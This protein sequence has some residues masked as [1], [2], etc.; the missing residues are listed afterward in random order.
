MEYM[1]HIHLVIFGLVAFVPEWRRT[2]LIIALFALLNIAYQ[3]LVDNAADEGNQIIHLIYA[4]VDFIA[5][6][7]LLWWGSKGEFSAKAIFTQPGAAR[8]LQAGILTFFIATNLALL[9]DYKAPPY[10]MY[11][12]YEKVIFALNIIQLFLISGGIYAVVG[13]TIKFILG[14]TPRTILGGIRN[15]YSGSHGTGSRSI[16]HRD[17][18]L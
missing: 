9:L 1:P 16:Q 12:A 11:Y 15:N 7:A 4:L 2:C 13:N 5:I 10:P 3:P 8:F 18:H 14:G 6:L 17:R